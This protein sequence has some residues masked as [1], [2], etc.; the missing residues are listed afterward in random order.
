MPYLFRFHLFQSDCAESQSHAAISDIGDATRYF[1]P[2]FSYAELLPPIT[3]AIF[4]TPEPD[5][6]AMI[7]E[8]AF[9]LIAAIVDY[10]ATP[11]LRFQLTLPRRRYFRHFAIAS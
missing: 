3:F 5:I 1:R 11:L 7:A 9:L 4:Y 10:L 8:A 6:T 2:P